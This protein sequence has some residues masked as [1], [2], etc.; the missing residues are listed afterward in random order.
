MF[1]LTIKILALAVILT[2]AGMFVSS[3]TPA[4]AAQNCAGAPYQ[5]W[6]NRGGDGLGLMASV[7]T[8]AVYENGNPINTAYTI[9][10][11]FPGGD[12]RKIYKWPIGESGRDSQRTF[13]TG[14]QLSGNGGIACNG[15]SVIGPGVDGHVGNGYVID[16]GDAFQHTKVTVSH[17]N[18]PG[19]ASGRWELRYNGATISNDVNNNGATVPFD[20]NN[21]GNIQL[22]L[23][24]HP[25]EPQGNVNAKRCQNVIRVTGIRDAFS[26]NP[27]SYV[28]L[29][30]SGGNNP[31]RFPNAGYRGGA[32]YDINVPDWVKNRTGGADVQVQLW[33][34]DATGNN[35]LVSQATI[36]EP[37]GNCN[38]QPGSNS[39]CTNA[40][41]RDDN[42]Q[43]SAGKN[44]YTLVTI[45]GTNNNQSD[46]TVG[47]N[48]GNQHTFGFRAMSPVITITAKRFFVGESQP[49]RTDTWQY[50]CLHASCEPPTY[51]SDGT[52]PNNI[53]RAGSQFTVFVPVR[54]DNTSPDAQVIPHEVGNP[55]RKFSV[56]EVAGANRIEHATNFGLY[57]G[58]RG[59]VPIT[60]TAPANVSRVSLSY[61]P[62]FYGYGALG[63]ATTGSPY[64]T[65]DIPVYKQ[66]ALEPHATLDYDSNEDPG[67]VTYRT[68]IR[69]NSDSTVSA[70]TT[71]N[72]TQTPYG[73]GARCANVGPVNTSGPWGA[74]TDT[75]TMGPGNCNP[76]S[77]SA[78]DRYC[79]RIE[80]TGGYNQGYVGPGGSGDVVLTNLNPTNA[81]AE[82]CFTVVNKPYFKAYNAGVS[83]GGDFKQSDGS[84]SSGSNGGILAGWNNNTGGN[85]RG[86]GSQLSSLAYIRITGFASAQTNITRSPTDLSFANTEASNINQSAD[87][88]KL[89]GNF[90]PGGSRC[91]TDVSPPP[92]TVNKPDGYVQPG[93]SGISNSQSVFVDGDVYINGNIE[94]AANWP[95]AN[96]PSF[97]LRASGNIYIAPGVTQLDGLYIARNKIY[98]CAENNGGGNFTPMAGGSVYNRCNNQLVVNGNF[99][100]KQVN[101]LRTL[102]SLRDEKPT[103]GRPAE[104]ATPE[105]VGLTAPLTVSTANGPGCTRIEEPN[106]NQFKPAYICLSPA[107]RVADKVKLAWTNSGKQG[108]GVNGL[109]N[110]TDEWSDILDNRKYKNDTRWR[111]DYLCSNVPIHIEDNVKAG[112]QCTNLS[113]TA[114]AGPLK[115]P[116]NLYLCLPTAAPAKPAVPA[117]PPSAPGA[118]ACSNRGSQTITSTCSGEVFRFTPALYLGTPSIQLPNG[119]AT[120]FDSITSLPPVL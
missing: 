92:G 18:N 99:S 112:E 27:Q 79:A 6:G 91:I 108:S 7:I 30:N 90:N 107:D 56:T 40:T 103:P 105:V 62:D 51:V 12:N 39:N 53:V 113:F 85:D 59:V 33:V 57:V 1:K 9:N 61:Y 23:I 29:T 69:N 28:L 93:V 15:W 102:G 110:C 31:D 4:Y 100:A 10:T 115:W 96:A 82:Q 88:P 65:V 38:D 8:Q 67:N 49:Y 114:G 116:S 25:E 75:N 42:R 37:W 32:N 77:V 76:T 16:C 17:V 44:S 70:P 89:G 24:W 55:V 109:N 98:T 13:S 46:Y 106:D 120:Q 60:Y 101:L 26:S 81:A 34:R 118:P 66:F 35:K 3:G 71:S 117:V 5:N 78:G 11:T 43:N 80:F 52:L 45:Q 86:A 104:A 47:R 54:N 72:F 36:Q 48:N 63:G 19:G 74:G 95:A 22:K 68:Y 2:G 119:G 20:V 41:I 73:G 87:S 97:V 50:Q 14:E 94:Y 64:C 84:C 111:D 21:G 83:A 58:D